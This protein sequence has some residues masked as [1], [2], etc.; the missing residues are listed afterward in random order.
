MS[1]EIF[2]TAAREISERLGVDFRIL[3]TPRFAR[4]DEDVPSLKSNRPGAPVRHSRAH[5]RRGAPRIEAFRTLNAAYARA[6]D[7]CNALSPF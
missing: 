3:S 7:T 5:P 2:A 4:G 1:T 6:I